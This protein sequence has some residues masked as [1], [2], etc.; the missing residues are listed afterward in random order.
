MMKDNR[1]RRVLCV[2]AA[3]VLLLIFF[4]LGFLVI[5]RISNGPFW[6]VLKVLLMCWILTIA[7]FCLFLLY[8]LAK[9]GVDSEPDVNL[10]FEEIFNS[11]N[12]SDFYLAH[13][14]QIPSKAGVLITQVELR[15]NM[16]V[17]CMDLR[18]EVDHGL[19][20]VIRENGMPFRM[21]VA[22]VA[23]DE[24][25]GCDYLSEIHV[26]QSGQNFVY[27]CEQPM[28]AAYLLIV[29]KSGASV[30][31]DEGSLRSFYEFAHLSDLH[32]SMVLQHVEEG[33]YAN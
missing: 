25:T 16:L 23:K 12:S 27:K 15:S 2:I 10:S 4:A 29:D 14:I 5:T 30:Y 9:E 22:E 20:R 7:A 17:I 3:G 1:R 31:V 11:E 18:D 28:M 24:S 8:T 26:L 19:L 21:M 13:L 6:L 32:E 33:E